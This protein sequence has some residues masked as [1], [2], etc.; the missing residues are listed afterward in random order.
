MT[1]RP[2][3]SPVEAMPGRA[4][5]AAR[6]RR[7]FRS[8][9]LVTRLLQHWRPWIC[10]FELLLEQ[11]P[12][13]ATVLDIGCGGGLFLGLLAAEGR[14]RGGVGFDASESAIR[15]ARAMAAGQAPGLLRF[16]RLDVGAPWPEGPFDVVALI[17][18]MHHVPT[19]ARRDLIRGAA[20]RIAPGG[21]LIYKDMCRRPRWRAFANKAHDL[22]LAGQWV[23]AEPLEHVRR[24]LADA[25]LDVGAGR[26]VN[27]LWYGHDLLVAERAG[28]DDRAA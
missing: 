13:G 21:R 5:L 23:D 3:A 2:P 17:D 20:A 18:V 11:V 1:A 10:P 24:W 27:R 26:R 28:G 4:A 22:L 15:T 14:I 12:A 25:G 6:A 9:P 16:E 8:G 19:D 7:L